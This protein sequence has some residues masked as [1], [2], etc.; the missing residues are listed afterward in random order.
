MQKAEEA[1]K[2][3]PVAAAPKPAA[4]APKPA[5]AQPSIENIV[6]GAPPPPGPLPKRILRNLN[7]INIK[8]VL[9]LRL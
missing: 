1:P 5:A 9:S 2:A 8:L 4:A 6:P 3:E 7:T